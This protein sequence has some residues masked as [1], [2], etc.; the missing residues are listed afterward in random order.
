MS[1]ISGAS[2]AQGVRDSLTVSQPPR[3]FP[4][5][6]LPAIIVLHLLPEGTLVSV[7]THD[8]LECYYLFDGRHAP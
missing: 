3:G 2:P 5:E 4:H 7:R 1:M 6:L 8:S